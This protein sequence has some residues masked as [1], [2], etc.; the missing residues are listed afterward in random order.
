MYVLRY[1]RPLLKIE[2]INSDILEYMNLY[3]KIKYWIIDYKYMIQGAFYSLVYRNPPKHYLEHI[4]HNKIPVVLIPGILEKWSA[5]KNMADSIS[6]AGH[7]VYIVQNLKYNIYSIPKSV[8][9]IQKILDKHDIKKFVFVAH[10]KGGL[11]GKYFL[12]HCN[13]NNH[14]LGMVAIASPFSGSAMTKLIPHD[15]FKELSVDSKIIHGLH[16]HPEINRSIVSIIP[17]YD[18]HVWSEKGSHLDGAKNIYVPV[19]GHHKIVY[20]KKVIEK[21]IQELER[22][23][24]QI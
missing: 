14:V 1:L 17:E 18:N 16:D 10:S 5:M 23:S 15:S 12:A 2:C 24:N 20:D 9:Y 21:T 4:I 7:P 19:H 8:E 11:I 22:L 3:H 13:K 6:L